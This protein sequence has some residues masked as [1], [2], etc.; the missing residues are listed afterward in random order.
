MGLPPKRTPTPRQHRRRRCCQSTCRGREGG[1]RVRSRAHLAG[2]E[3]PA[4]LS[5]FF[6][7]HQFDLAQPTGLLNGHH[8][9]EE[10]I[11]FA[12][13]HAL[14]GRIAHG[15]EGHIE[16]IDRHGRDDA[17]EAVEKDRT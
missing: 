6:A 12:I 9:V 13:D 14:R 3:P 7:K 8:R 5:S 1:D 10:S 17:K 16:H 4:P 15:G 11:D 2:M